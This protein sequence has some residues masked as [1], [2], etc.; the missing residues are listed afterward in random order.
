[1]RALS[2]SL[3]CAL[4]ASGCARAAPSPARDAAVDAPAPRASTHVCYGAAGSA[5]EVARDT[6]CESLG[7]SETPPATVPAPPPARRT[8][9]PRDAETLF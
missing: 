8:R 5:V 9:E 6:P 7:A 4:V 2:L 1:M 3:A